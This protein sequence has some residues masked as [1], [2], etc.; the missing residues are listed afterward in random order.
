MAKLFE[1][2]RKFFAWELKAPSWIFFQK[3]MEWWFDYRDKTLNTSYQY[4]EDI[5]K[6]SFWRLME[7]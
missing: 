1:G 7:D 2:L 3:L 5:K 6:P 4:K